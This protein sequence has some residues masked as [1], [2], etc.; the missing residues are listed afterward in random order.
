MF[1][2]YGTSRIGAKWVYGMSILIPSIMSIALPSVILH[3]YEAGLFV[4]GFL[5]L[6]ASGNDKLMTV[7]SI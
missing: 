5:G 3:S 2:S 1:A 7:L 4:R 6:C